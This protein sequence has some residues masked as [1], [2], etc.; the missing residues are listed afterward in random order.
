MAGKGGSLYDQALQQFPALRS[1]DMQSK[2]NIGGGPGY[3]EFWPPGESGTPDH[4]RPKDF[5]M[6]RPGTEIYRKDTKPSDVAADITSHW[7]VNNDPTVKGNYE[8]FLGQITPNQ[9]GTLRNQ[10]E[11]AKKNEGETRAYE[12]WLA[13][14]GEPAAYRG[15]PFGQWPQEFNDKFY[16]PAQRD[17][18]DQLL[19]YLKTPK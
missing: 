7:L 3:L 19:Q 9:Q 18:L 16:T 4:P 14:T 17:T 2:S 15:Y 13:A 1:V 10:Y 12:E 8:K 11:W 5:A 6:D